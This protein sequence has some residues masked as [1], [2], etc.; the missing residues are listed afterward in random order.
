[1]YDKLHAELM[2][3]LETDEW[4]YARIRSL[5]WALQFLQTHA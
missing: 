2:A 4:D 1:M 5:A 3:I